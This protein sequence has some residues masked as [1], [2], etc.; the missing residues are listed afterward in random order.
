M[1]KHRIFFYFLRLTL[2]NKGQKDLFCTTSIVISTFPMKPT[3]LLTLSITALMLFSCMARHTSSPIAQE[4]KAWH[5]KTQIPYYDDRYTHDV[6]MWIEGDTTVDGLACKKL[7]KHTRLRYSD[8]EGT[9]QVGY[10][11]QEGERYYQNGELLFDL[12]LEV[13][14]TF[15]PHR[16]MP[17][18]VKAIGDTILT[19]GLRR[20]FLMVAE[21]AEPERTFYRHDYWVEGIGSL[22]M[23]ILT[24]DFISIGVMKRLLHCTY[25]G[26]T[27]YCYKEDR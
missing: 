12:G 26:D 9:L 2:G 16:G 6:H 22:Q 7:Y 25:D 15:V 10:C 8:E 5:I 3:H 1:Q 13:G 11:R 14:D 4:G 21:K 24:N 27:L 20:K 17:L 19:D 23:G 18:I